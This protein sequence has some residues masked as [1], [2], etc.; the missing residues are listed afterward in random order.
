MMNE[1]DKPAGDWQPVTRAGQ[2]KVGDK[3]RFWIG[4]TGYAETARQ[5][6]HAG[7]DA[8][9][10][11]YN[12]RNNYYF[13]TSMV[14]NGRSNH[15]RVEVLSAPDVAKIIGD[16]LDELYV[17]DASPER[18][19]P[20]IE[21]DEKWRAGFERGKRYAHKQ[22]CEV[23]H[24]LMRERDEWK[25][26]ANK[27][28]GSSYEKQGVK[29]KGYADCKCLPAQYC[30]GKCRP[31][32]ECT[33]PPELPPEHVQPS[34][35][36]PEFRE[37]VGKVY[38]RTSYSF[39]TLNSETSALIAHID[40][41]LAQAR[42]TRNGGRWVPV[43]ERDEWKAKAIAAEEKLASIRAEVEALNRYGNPPYESPGIMD[44]GWML[45]R[46][47]VLELFQKQQ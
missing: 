12:K 11:I 24:A 13:I 6:L 38:G 42:D 1:T 45:M 2:V 14:I 30:D 33:L 37:L 28:Q 29:L 25:A 10:V 8:E 3:L 46:E 43:A 9:E 7:T 35:D 31:I 16:N 5:I 26:K 4:D 36:T 19:Q 40:A 34:I 17:T 47:E 32:F 23:T 27:S 22:A 44:E 20:S 21:N 39:L 41:K 15:K 18:L